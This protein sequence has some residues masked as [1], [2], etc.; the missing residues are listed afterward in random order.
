MPRAARLSCFEKPTSAVR[1]PPSSSLQNHLHPPKP[2]L[3]R[4]WKPNCRRNQNPLE[5]EAGRDA[6]HSPT[7]MPRHASQCQHMRRWHVHQERHCPGSKASNFLQETPV[8]AQ[9]A[10]FLPQGTARVQNGNPPSRACPKT[11]WGLSG[12]HEKA[13]GETRG[14]GGPDPTHTAPGPLQEVCSE[15]VS[16]CKRQ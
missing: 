12:E 9:E 1:G 3:P 5:H 11:S 15:P 16:I 4:S 8:A 13:A 6:R 2:D 10:V 14:T 7:R